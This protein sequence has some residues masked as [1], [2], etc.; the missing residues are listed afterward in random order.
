MA[1]GTAIHNLQ[2]CPNERTGQGEGGPASRTIHT[3]TMRIHIYSVLDIKCFDLVIFFIYLRVIHSLIHIVTKGIQR[4]TMKPLCRNHFIYQI[5]HHL[6]Y[7]ESRLIEMCLWMCRVSASALS[8]GR[9][10]PGGGWVYSSRQFSPMERLQQTG[11]WRK[12][13]GHSWSWYSRSNAL[14]IKAVG[15]Q[16]HGMRIWLLSWAFSLVNVSFS[17][18]QVMRYWKWM[19]SLFKA[20]RTSKP[21]RPSR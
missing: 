14:V 20:S 5:H 2:H 17:S 21:F 18:I 13:D 11:D 1:T 16:P 19:E 6:C 8:V 9:I 3:V 7:C 10:Q 12:V 15:P 4:C